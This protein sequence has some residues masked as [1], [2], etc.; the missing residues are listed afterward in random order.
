[1]TGLEITCCILLVLAILVIGS[2]KFKKNKWERKYYFSTEERDKLVCEKQSLEKLVKADH[3]HYST[4]RK[5]L[6]DLKQKQDEDCNCEDEYVEETSK[7]IS[8]GK[9]VLDTNRIKKIDSFKVNDKFK[10]RIDYG[11]SYVG[12]YYD[13]L[14]TQ[15][16]IMENIKTA[17][18]VYT[19]D[20]FIKE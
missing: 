6:S 3:E 8:I 5:E 7:F 16:Q 12:F 4:L 14:D 13:D 9:Y 2:L 15:K 11:D 1:M 20:E 19:V 10:I 18:N 17:L